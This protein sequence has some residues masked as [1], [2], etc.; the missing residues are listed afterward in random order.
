MNTGSNEGYSVDQDTPNPPPSPPLPPL[1]SATIDEAIE[2]APAAELKKLV[3]QLMADIPQVR[4]LIDAALLR[5]LGNGLK[6][7]AHETCVNCHEDYL[8][9]QNPIGICRYHPCKSL[10]AFAPYWSRC[11]LTF[12]LYPTSASTGG[13]RR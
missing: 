12:I 2:D 1:Q 6:R 3:R 4:P 9:E 8:V 5:P 11:S 7:K 10:E 13:R